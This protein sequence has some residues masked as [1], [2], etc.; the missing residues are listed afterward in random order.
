[1]Y[2][3]MLLNLSDSECQVVDLNSLRRGIWRVLA[4]HSKFAPTFNNLYSYFSHRGIDSIFGS[5]LRG[6]EKI[7]DIE[8]ASDLQRD[9]F[10]HALIRASSDLLDDRTCLNLLNQLSLS[11]VSL[12][13]SDILSCSPG[14]RRWLRAQR[15][16]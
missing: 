5:Y 8:S 10:A 2:F 13:S 11:D 4:K 6:V 12:S 1:M 14:V 3:K 16:L 7:I 15:L 9:E